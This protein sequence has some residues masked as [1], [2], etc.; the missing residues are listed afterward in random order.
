M[1]PSEVLNSTQ[2]EFLHRI[3]WEPGL[4]PKGA[5]WTIFYALESRNLAFKRDMRVYASE[6]G[7]AL[8][9]V[10]HQ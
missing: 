5:E 1:K 7:I 10:T 4:K 2:A 6:L 8:D 3:V 9:K